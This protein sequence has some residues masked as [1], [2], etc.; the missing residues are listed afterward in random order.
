[1]SQARSSQV[2]GVGDDWLVYVV[3]ADHADPDG[4]GAELKARGWQRRGGARVSVEGMEGAHVYV[5]LTEAAAARK[6]Q[7]AQADE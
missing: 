7:E 2:H 6:A 1:M 3:P 4:I 5:R